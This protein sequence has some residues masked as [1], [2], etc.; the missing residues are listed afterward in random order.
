MDPSRITAELL[1]ATFLSGARPFNSGALDVSGARPAAVA[2]PISLAP[3]PLLHLVLRSGHLADH[4]GEIGFPG[5]KPDPGDA[6]L[7]ATAGREMLEETGVG[8]AQVEWLGELSPCPVI[9]GRFVIHPFAALLEDGVLPRVASGE[10]T[11]VLTLPLAP[12]LSGERRM[13]AIQAEWHGVQVTAPHFRLDRHVLYG[14][15]AY[16]AYELLLR[17]ATALGRELPPP[18][19]EADAPWGKRYAGL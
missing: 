3:V 7:R 17:L 6:D 5:G 10:I 11:E 12:F 8:E 18:E 19:I 16:I 13:Q 4:A 15:T 9:T 2:V 1:R 14:A